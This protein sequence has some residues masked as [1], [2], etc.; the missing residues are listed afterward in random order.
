VRDSRRS[1]FV[2]RYFLRRLA[3]AQRDQRRSRGPRPP[4]EPPGDARAYIRALSDAVAL[5]VLLPGIALFSIGASISLTVES[6]AL[7]MAQAG[8][9]L[10][11]VLL[12]TCLLVLLGHIGLGL[13]L[14]RFRGD[15][16]AARA[17]DT[18]RD[19]EIAFWQRLIVTA[20]CGF[21][22]PLCALAILS[23]G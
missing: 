22:A 10:V 11:A 5:F 13:R 6:P 21:A 1:D 20:L 23:N 4:L 17:F 18:D 14:R 2:T 15:S 19:R 3:E 12:V 16:S 9:P 7:S 8:S